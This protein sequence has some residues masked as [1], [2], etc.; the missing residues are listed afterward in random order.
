MTN[1]FNLGIPVGHAYTVQ[2]TGAVKTIYDIIAAA[3]L[4]QGSSSCTVQITASG[5][6]SESIAAKFTVDGDTVPT[7][8]GAASDNGFVVGNYE[9]IYL[10]N[11]QM[12]DNFKIIRGE[13]ID[14]IFVQVQFYKADAW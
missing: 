2:L 8:T 10:K 4:T 5:L 14:T 13:A 1:F 9:I 11:K 6:T 3:S 7:S 12:I